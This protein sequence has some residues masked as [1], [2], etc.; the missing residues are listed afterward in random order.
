MRE[1]VSVNEMKKIV[2]EISASESD[3]YGIDIKIW[4]L[5]FID[6]FNTNFDKGNYKEVGRGVKVTYNGKDVTDKAIISYSLNGSLKLTVSSL[7]DAINEL[8][9]GEEAV[10]TYSV[11]YLTSPTKKIEKTIKIN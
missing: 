10:I 8:E 5:S 1:K 9:S 2:E 3:K 11:K 4:P 6:I 7:E